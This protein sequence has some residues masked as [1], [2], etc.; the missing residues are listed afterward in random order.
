[1]G[2]H[3]LRSCGSEY[4]QGM[5]FCK[6]NN[7]LAQQM[8]RKS[9]LAEDLSAS[10]GGICSMDL[11]TQWWDKKK[12][13]ELLYLLNCKMRFF[14]YIWH[15]NMWGCL[16]FV[17]EVPNQI[18]LNQTMW[19]QIKACTVKS[20]CETCAPHRHYAEYSG[21]YSL[22]FWDMSVPSSMVKKSKRE[23]TARLKLND[24]ILFVRTQSSV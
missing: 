3:V 4:R 10:Q 18:A 13:Y 19:S 16:Q 14:P 11:V 1:M 12:S 5:G 6:H 2:S 9:W 7:L 22:M 15:L 21:N 20:S 8:Y 24:T 23:N 17:H